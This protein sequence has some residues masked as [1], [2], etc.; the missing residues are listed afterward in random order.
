MGGLSHSQPPFSGKYQGQF[1]SIFEDYKVWIG[2][3]WRCFI[4]S[5][6]VAR[7]VLIKFLDVLLPEGEESILLGEDISSKM[8]LI[9]CDLQVIGQ[10]IPSHEIEVIIEVFRAELIDFQL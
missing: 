10:G 7:D 4:Y 3:I 8:I 9:C 5:D 2:E 1:L 6:M